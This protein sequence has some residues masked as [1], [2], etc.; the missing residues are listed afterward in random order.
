MQIPDSMRILC[1]IIVTKYAEGL[2]IQL[3]EIRSAHFI[4][5]LVQGCKKAEF[6]R[7]RD[8]NED[9]MDRSLSTT[10]RYGQEPKKMCRK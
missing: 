2:T 6:T 7:I 3:H 8:V 5:L 9:M 4:I 10:G 1:K